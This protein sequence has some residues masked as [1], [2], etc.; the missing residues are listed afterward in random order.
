MKKTHLGLGRR[1]F[2]WMFSLNCVSLYGCQH[3]RTD[4]EGSRDNSEGGQGCLQWPHHR[5]WLSPAAKVKGRTAVEPGKSRLIN[6]PEIMS[7]LSMIVIGE[8]ALSQGQPITPFMRF[9]FVLLKTP[10]QYKHKKVRSKGEKEDYKEK[11][12]L[13]LLPQSDQKKHF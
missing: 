9:F 4:Q 1:T 7:L 13:N 12:I 10:K 2:L 8:V 3:P 5:A 6:F 11:L